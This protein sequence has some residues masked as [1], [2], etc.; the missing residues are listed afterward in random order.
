MISHSISLRSLL[1]QPIGSS[2]VSHPT[3]LDPGV[4]RKISHPASFPLSL[5]VGLFKATH[6]TPPPMYPRAPHRIVSR[7]EVDVS[8]YSTT[9]DMSY[10]AQAHRH[11]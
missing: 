7:N 10:I 9:D 8:R 4:L 2:Y 11:T 6:P 1:F 5:L 3:P